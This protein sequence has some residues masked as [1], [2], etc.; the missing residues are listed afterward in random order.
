MKFTREQLLAQSTDRH[1]AVVANAG[2]G[3]TA[4]LVNRYLSLLL[5]DADVREIAAIT[6]TKKA[7]AEMHKRVA[8]KLEEVLADPEKQARWN[9]VKRMRERLSSARISTIHSF[10]ARLLRDFPIEAGIN[11]NF[12]ELTEYEAAVLKR[13]SITETLELWLEDDGE[14]RAQALQLVRTFDRKTVEHYLLSLLKSAEHFQIVRALYQSNNNEQLLAV[15]RTAFAAAVHAHCSVAANGF[16]FVFDS[17]TPDDFATAKKTREQFADA[18]S[19]FG[20]LEEKLAAFP[21]QPSWDDTTHL[22]SLL[23]TVQSALCTQSYTLKSTIAR[24]IDNHAILAESASLLAASLPLLQDA[25]ALCANHRT[26]ATLLLHARALCAMASEA[27]QAMNKEKERLGVLDFDDLQLYAARLLENPAVAETI[28]RRFRYIMIDEFQDTNELQYSI[29]R[30]MV[31]ALLHCERD[32]VELNNDINFFIVGDPKQSIYG[33]R[34]ADVRVFD[35]AQQHIQ[36][37]N[38]RV[39]P[40]YESSMPHLQHEYF[41]NVRLSASFRLLPVVA[42][43]VNRVCGFAMGV[44]ASEFDVDYEPLVCGRQSTTPDAGN[45]SVTLVVAQKRRGT[46]FSSDEEEPNDEEQQDGDSPSEAELLTLHLKSMVAS[47]TPALVWER[48]KHTAGEVPRPARWGDIA[49]LARSKTGFNTLA[50]SLRRHGI[51]FVINSGTGYYDRQEILDMRSFLLFLQNSSDDIALA[52]IFRAPFFGISD[53]ELYN[54][55]AC[56]GGSLW[57]RTQSYYQTYGNSACTPLFLRAWTTLT[58]L[59]PLAPRVTIPSLIRLILSRTGWRGAIAGE[60]RYEQ[61]QANMEKLLTLARDFENRGFKNLYDFAEEL[62]LLAQYSDTEG[63]AEIAIGKDAVQIMTI[64]ASKGLEFPIVALYQTASVNKRTDSFYADT[65]FGACFKVPVFAND[66]LPTLTETPL[67]WLAVQ[68]ARERENAERKR[69]LYVAL[70]RAE[71]HLVISGTVSISASGD[72]GALDGFLRDIADAL[73]LPHADLRFNQTLEFRDTLPLLLDGEKKEHLLR[74]TTRISTT[75]SDV[76]YPV[77][78][79]T[80][81]APYQLPPLLLGTPPVFVQGDI[82]SASQLQLFIAN[83]HEYEL[84]YRLGLPPSEDTA[85]YDRSRLMPEE[86]DG[87]A[88]ALPGTLIHAVLAALP[89]WLGTTGIIDTAALDSLI[90]R[91]LLEH[92]LPL[93]HP[94]AERIRR[95]TR[96]VASH[97]FLVE[98]AA[99]LPQAQFEYPFH[100]YTGRDYIIGSVDALVPDASGNLEIWD[101]KTNAV[102]SDFDMYR[103][104]ERYR[105]QLEVYAWFLAHFRPEQERITTRLLFT[106]RAST[107]KTP[108]QWIQTLHIE[109]ADIARTEVKAKSIMDEIRRISYGS[110]LAEQTEEAYK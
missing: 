82:Y 23:A 73:E 85:D 54:I 4:V 29:T 18:L 35:K 34:G 97:P 8:E 103:L 63:E 72:V 74:Y 91:K 107:E 68:K 98:R 36:L 14:K 15:V 24:K 99:T 9:E 17:L 25:D 26:D 92:G 42:A 87:V 45:G 1:L 104:F 69:V 11:P 61:M 37:V 110:F 31:S 47:E 32:E 65:T 38:Q 100:M 108:E 48:A 62:Q 76:V 109:R 50:A 27:Q 33:F 90:E 44:R 67:Y 13:T 105:L 84:V 3:K 41:G 7:A 51:P 102:T 79:T 49:V 52:S 43:F 86:T 96:A 88:G 64:H 40:A 59:L 30:N 80:S 19:S 6:F 16:R 39:L 21:A 46:S 57:E 12:T 10:C 70:T 20:I 5:N 101:W 22:L 55:S 56:T 81:S 95:E 89:T 60:E 106:R 66:S 75:P 83:P 93:A 53:T 28:S 77:A 58:E 78:D 71:N 94:A 2:S